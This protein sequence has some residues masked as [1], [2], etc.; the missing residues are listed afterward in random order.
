M[1]D[2]LLPHT[3]TFP[4]LYLILS[5]TFIKK[6]KSLSHVCSSTSPL[7]LPLSPS[8][9]VNSLTSSSLQLII[10]H[11]HLSLSPSYLLNSLNSSSLQLI[12]PPISYLNHVL[13]FFLISLWSLQFYCYLSCKGAF[14]SLWFLCLFFVVVFTQEL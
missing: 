6:K 1:S 7:H 5:H 3:F 2:L 4:S 9:L 12:T 13:G 8:H 11:F 10:S 14:F